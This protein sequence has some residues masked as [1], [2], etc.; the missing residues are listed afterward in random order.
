MVNAHLVL[1]T[2][3]GKDSYPMNIKVSIKKKYKSENNHRTSMDLLS[4]LIIEIKQQNAVLVLTFACVPVA[5]LTV[6][7]SGNLHTVRTGVLY[8]NLEDRPQENTMF[9]KL[10]VHLVWD[11]Q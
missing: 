2:R 4:F 9:Y 3:N 10:T 6:Y 11:F 1:Y 5:V 7:L 8:L